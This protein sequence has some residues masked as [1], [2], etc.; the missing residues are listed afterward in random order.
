MVETYSSFY[1]PHFSEAEIDELIAFYSSNLGQKDVRSTRMATAEFVELLKNRVLDQPRVDPVREFSD[2][3]FLI[4]R[5]CN[6]AK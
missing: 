2:Q 3:M 4:A 5:E 1:G 6:C